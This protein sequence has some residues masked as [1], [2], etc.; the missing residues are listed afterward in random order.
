MAAVMP[1]RPL[2]FG[3]PNRGAA[4]PESALPSFVARRLLVDDVDPAAP[5]DQL[6]VAVATHEGLQRV[7]DL[8]GSIFVLR[9]CRMRLDG[10]AVIHSP[11]CKTKSAEVLSFRAAVGYRAL[12]RFVKLAAAGGIARRAR[13]AAAIALR[14]CSDERATAEPLGS[15]S[16][17]L[18]GRGEARYSR[19]LRG[20]R[21]CFKQLAAPCN[22]QHPAT[23]RIDACQ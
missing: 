20:R 7:L 11:A 21:A 19:R 1:R 9:P 23:R 13:S 3:Q 14:V 10:A 6:V 17:R 22:S 16:A 4:R 5:A 18:A 2:P 12:R 15:A 8:H